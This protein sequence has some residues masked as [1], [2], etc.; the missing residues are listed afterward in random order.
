VLPLGGPFCAA[1]PF[2]SCDADA[3]ML[4]VADTYYLHGPQTAWAVTFVVVNELGARAAL[5]V[6][7]PNPLKRLTVRA[8][9]IGIAEPVPGAEP[10]VRCAFSLEIRDP[11][12]ALAG[13]TITRTIGRDRADVTI[14]N[15][16]CAQLGG[17]QCTRDDGLIWLVK[18]DAV[19]AKRGV[20]LKVT[21]VNAL[22]KRATATMVVR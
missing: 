5:K 11:D 1:D 3:G 22:G 12:A 21:V 9:Q 13:G 19:A 6:L 4:R 2:L 8:A 17:L 16:L 10:A 15:D 20:P 14:G 7:V 18:D